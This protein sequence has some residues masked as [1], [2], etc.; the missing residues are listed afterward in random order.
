TF[1]IRGVSQPTVYPRRERAP[2]HRIVVALGR[3]PR[4][5]PLAEL[6]RIELGVLAPEPQKS[7]FSLDVRLMREILDVHQDRIRAP[8]R[9]CLVVRGAAG[10]RRARDDQEVAGPLP[11]AVALVDELLCGI[12]E[13]LASGVE[14]D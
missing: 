2:V 12:V 13:R 6:F 4:V 11:V 5:R 8:V 3:A 1:A 7:D 14:E 10:L 9:Q